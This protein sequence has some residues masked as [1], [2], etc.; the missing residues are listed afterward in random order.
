MMSIRKTLGAACVALAL[1]GCD[2]PSEST[3]GNIDLV[4]WW[5]APGEVQALEAVV[6][7]F[8]RRYPNQDISI[9]DEITNSADAR[10]ELRSRILDGQPPDAFQANGG[11]DLLA[12][13]RYDPNDEKEN[14]MEAIEDLGIEGGWDVIPA[15]VLETVTD[16][17]H[18]YA[19]PLNVHRTNVLFYSKKLFAEANLPVPTTLD[20]LFDVA[21]KFQDR[22]V[23][24][25]GLGAEAAWTLQ[26][27]LFENLLV[28]RNGGRYY[29]EFFRD[30]KDPF[31]FEMRRAV[32]DLRR[33]LTFTNQDFPGQPWTRGIDLVLQDQAA[34]TIMGDW[35]KGYFMAKGRRPDMDFGMV[36]MPGT[37][38]TFVFTTDTFA[39]PKGALNPGGAKDFLRLLASKDGQEVFNPIKGSI[40]ARSDINRENPIYD[41]MAKMTID[42]FQDALPDPHRLVPAMAILAPPNYIA[43]IDKALATFSFRLDNPGVILHAMKNWIDVLP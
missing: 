11:W 14:K 25:I 8:E 15:P 19:V 37:E 17:G 40:P 6:G 5:Q 9:A 27:L 36:P 3:I 10:D 24:P 2:A 1:A 43:A 21:K 34:M 26:L 16:N 35:A 28:A 42:H 30:P 12:W 18:I 23:T 22:G 39:I 7:L 41:G 13:V 4:S 31:S 33:L 32:E 20:E 38:G 29:V